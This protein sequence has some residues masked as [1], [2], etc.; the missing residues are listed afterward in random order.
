MKEN[1]R[2]LFVHISPLH[3]SFIRKD[4]DIL[5]DIGETRNLFFKSRLDI[6]KLSLYTAW[7]DIVFCWFAWDNAYWA[8]KFSK[9]LNKKTLVVVGGFDVACIPEIRYGN[10]LYPRSARKTRYVLE[11]ATK[12]IAVS[13]FTKREASRY[14]DR[15]DLD[16]IYLGF[17][18]ENFHTTTVPKEKLVITVGEVNRSNMMRK[19]L[20][21]F[22]EAAKHLPELQFALVGK[23]SDESA[24]EG[25]SLPSNLNIVGYVSDSELLNFMQRASVYVQVSAHEGFGCSLAEAMLCECVPVVTRNGAIPEVVGDTGYYV[26]YNEPA[27][28]ADAIEK[29]LTD[30]VKGKRARRRIA[31]HF[32]LS[33]RKEKL[34]DVISELID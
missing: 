34:E 9:L 6:P 32:P 11:N 33:R 28:T 3:I 27:G 12:L 8:V 2:I 17:D 24:L 22:I 7:S 13:E 15:K 14:C 21:S 29:A 18:P 31:T 19:G 10:M 16:I 26:P 30:R 23:V 20:K 25:T 4:F 1:S 5:K